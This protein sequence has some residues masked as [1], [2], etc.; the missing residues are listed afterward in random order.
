M[1]F[2]PLPYC[3]FRAI[4]LMQLKGIYLMEAS[5]MSKTQP[6]EINSE[7]IIWRGLG[8]R[9]WGEIKL[10]LPVQNVA[11]SSNSPSNRI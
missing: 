9:L 8:E 6:L 7:V 10:E 1:A 3:G 5:L 4:Y 11:S 2:Q